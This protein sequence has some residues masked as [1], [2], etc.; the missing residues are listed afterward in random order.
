VTTRGAL[1]SA[2]LI[3]LGAGLGVGFPASKRLSLEP[4]LCWTVDVRSPNAPKLAP[5]ERGIE[6]PETCAARLEAVRLMRGGS[7][8]GAYEGVYLFA[9]DRGLDI[10]PSLDGP[11][12]EFIAPKDR[13][14][15]DAAIGELIRQRAAR[16]GITVERAV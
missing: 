4:G 2:L 9:D 8:L 15:I 1:L 6:N 11:R 16:E 3:I 5:L 13:R 7:V 10:A 12:R 14:R